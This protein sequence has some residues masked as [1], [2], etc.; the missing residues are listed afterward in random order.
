MALKESLKISFAGHSMPGCPSTSLSHFSFF[1]LN[2]WWPVW[3][4]HC[5]F[6][7]SLCWLTSPKQLFNFYSLR[8]QKA[9]I[10]LLDPGPLG[11]ALFI[12]TIDPK[13]ARS[14][15]GDKVWIFKNLQNAIVALA[16]VISSP[17]N[18]KALKII[19]PSIP[20][21]SNVTSIWICI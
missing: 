21:I 9:F 13:V 7:S 16:E 19:C 1:S 3:C 14:E 10:S 17:R 4:S 15:E 6:L 12:S 18:R 20:S 2:C 5:T 8:Q 11:N